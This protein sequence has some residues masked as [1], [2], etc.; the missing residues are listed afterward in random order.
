MFTVVVETKNVSV[1][2]LTPETEVTSET[3]TTGS[4]LHLVHNI[5]LNN[6]SVDVVT[7]GGKCLLVH[8]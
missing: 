6:G 5:V 8:A 7:D 4:L 3:G 1:L 2:C